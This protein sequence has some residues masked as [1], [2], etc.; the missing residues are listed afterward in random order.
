M[1]DERTETDRLF[2]AVRFALVSI[3]L[4]LAYINIRACLA[5]PQFRQIFADMLEGQ[6]LPPFTAVVFQMRH[7]F[8]AASWLLPLGAICTMFTSV[9]A[10]S[11]Y[12]IGAIA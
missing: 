5:I 12:V 9:K 3:T 11:F 8:L 7:W 10:R 2:R 6:A 4:G 1:N